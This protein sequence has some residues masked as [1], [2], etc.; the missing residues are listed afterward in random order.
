MSLAKWLSIF[1]FILI[2]V[3]NVFGFI[4][5]ASPNVVNTHATIGLATLLVGL[6]SMIVMLKSKR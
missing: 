1:T 2:V 4:A 6:L 5:K 3:A